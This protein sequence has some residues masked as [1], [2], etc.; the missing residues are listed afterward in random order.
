MGQRIIYV[1]ALACW[2][3]LAIGLKSNKNKSISRDAKAQ[4]LKQ[5]FDDFVA[6]RPRGTPAPPAGSTPHKKTRRGGK[7]N[8]R[9]D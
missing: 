4:I 7:K 8:K 9:N 1:D 2:A 5:S 3:C 6:P